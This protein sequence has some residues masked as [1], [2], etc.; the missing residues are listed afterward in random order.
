MDVGKGNI[1]GIMNGFKQFVIPVYQRLYSWEIEQ[2]STL[3]HDIVSLEKENK[4]SHFVGSI[5][6]IAENVMPTGVQRFMIIDG[7][8]RLTTLSLLMIALWNFA[9]K[10]PGEC[11]LKP[12]KIN[13]MFLENEDESGEDQYKLLLTEADKETFISLVENRPLPEQYSIHIKENYDYFVKQIESRTLELDQVYKSIGKLQIVNI[14]LEASDDPQAIFESL[15]STG[16][17]LSQSDLIRNNVLM[18][19]DVRTQSLVYHD[20]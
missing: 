4:A 9:E 11:E 8:Q 3:W 15:N 10:H 16:K 20:L 1:F 7:Q 6:N 2:C 13:H 14:T 5:V 12:S 18:G 17:G 19:L